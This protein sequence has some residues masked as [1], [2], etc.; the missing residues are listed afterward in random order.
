MGC[1]VKSVKASLTRNIEGAAGTYRLYKLTS[2][3]VRGLKV[4]T[5]HYKFSKRD[6]RQRA[7][8]ASKEGEFTH[9]KIARLTFPHTPSTYVR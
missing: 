6:H 4:I 2:Y 5:K 7:Y 8:R 9:C 3:T 1:V